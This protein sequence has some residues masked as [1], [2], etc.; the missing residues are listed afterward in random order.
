LSRER[1]AG[2]LVTPGEELDPDV[3]AQPPFVI[4]VDG[5]K[6]A[7]VVGLYQE[8]EG[9]KHFVRLKGPYVPR[10]G[11][12]VIG[13]VTG[14]GIMNWYVDLNSPYNGVL[15]VND[16]LGRPFNPAVDDMSK[17]LRVGDY[18]KVKIVAFDKTR[19][20]LLTVQDKDLGRIVTGTVVEIAPA[21]VPRVIGRKRS[22]LEMLEK[23][24]ECRFFVAVNGR[25]HIECPNKELE[26]IAV[27]AVKMIEREA[28]TSGLTERVMKFIQEER[29]IREV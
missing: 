19:N 4:E 20:P 15:S 16:F 25:I 24:T 18:V 8:R 1:L 9:K 6:I 12:V 27:L 2:R 29:R 10:P 13:L 22:M 5:R 28:H 11:D 21:K 26:A 14:V 17:M 3:E 7:T 23:E